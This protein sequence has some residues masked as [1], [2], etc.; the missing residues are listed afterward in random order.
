M[1]TYAYIHAIAINEKGGH[2][3]EGEQGVVYEKVWR[4]EREERNEIILSQKFKRKTIKRNLG[5]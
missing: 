2:E 4:E 3:S 5:N 1:Y